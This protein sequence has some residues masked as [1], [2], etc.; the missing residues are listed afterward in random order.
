MH[1]TL[2]GLFGKARHNRHHVPPSQGRDS[3]EF[4]GGVDGVNTRENVVGR[5]FEGHKLPM[6]P[7]GLWGVQLLLASR[8]ELLWLLGC[9]AALGLHQDNWTATSISHIKSL[10]NGGVREWFLKSRLRLHLSAIPFVPPL[11]WARAN[12]TGWLLWSERVL[13]RRAVCVARELIW[14]F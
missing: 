3:F 8:C 11:K 12:T 9:W 13:E 4:S 10:R 14:P 1:V 2:A 6:N 5:V 7:E